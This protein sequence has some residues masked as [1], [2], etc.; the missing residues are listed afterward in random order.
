LAGEDVMSKI[1]LI[2]HGQANYEC[3]RSRKFPVV[4]AGL[5]PLSTK[6]INQAMVVVNDERLNDAELIV[7]SPYTRALQTAAIISNVKGLKINVEF[8]L[9]EWLP[10]TSFKIE[11]E[12]QFYTALHSFREN[13]GLY[14][15]QA[16]LWEQ[17]SDIKKRVLG[18]LLQ[19]SKYR[20]IIVVTHGEVIYCLTGQKSTENC[21]I[22]EIELP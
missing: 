13:D 16:F 12:S 11:D 18:C 9:H 17:I 3:M 22:A 20:K 15:G 7:S 10:D 8:D 14:H 19:Y 4:C 6:G 5:A 2:R 1:I 21:G